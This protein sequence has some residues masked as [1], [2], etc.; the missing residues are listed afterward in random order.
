M[1]LGPVEGIQPGLLLRE[2]E[3][4]KKS[5]TSKGK[6]SLAVLGYLP[7][8]RRVNVYEAE[9][10]AIEGERSAMSKEQTASYLIDVVAVLTRDGETRVP[11]FHS[12]NLKFQRHCS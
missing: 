11:K 9:R 7:A 1:C 6:G 12:S 10:A 8:E 3:A 5:G 4:E 2:G